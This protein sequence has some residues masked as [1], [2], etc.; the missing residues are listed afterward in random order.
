MTSFHRIGTTQYL[1]VLE[2]AHILG[3]SE[4]TVR[5]YTKNGI[6]KVT[7]HP[8]SNFRL[9]KRADVDDVL[10]RLKGGGAK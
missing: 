6:I 2:V 1:G 3:V 5:R 7:R 8:I 9:Y 10:S 4:S